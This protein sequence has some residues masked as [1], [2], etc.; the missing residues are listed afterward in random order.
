MVEAARG[1]GGPFTIGDNCARAS[2][3]RSSG[4]GRS[5]RDFWGRLLTNEKRL[6]ENTHRFFDSRPPN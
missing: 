4:A 6:A 5:E 2:W 3:K 1:T